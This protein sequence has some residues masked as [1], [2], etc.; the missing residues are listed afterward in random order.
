MVSAIAVSVT[1]EYI[2]AG[3][4]PFWRNTMSLVMRSG[5]LSR[6]TANAMTRTV[7]AILGYVQYHWM[8][9]LSC[10]VSC[11]AKPSIPIVFRLWRT[12]VPE[13]K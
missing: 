13:C 10:L 8:R 1:A 3:W 12:H 6:H 5:S 2:P 9:F 11:C 4:K 7:A